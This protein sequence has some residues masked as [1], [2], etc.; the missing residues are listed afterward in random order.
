MSFNGCALTKLKPRYSMVTVIGL[1]QHRY[2][3]SSF[4]IKKVHICY[5]LDL[6]YHFSLSLTKFSMM[7]HLKIFCDVLQ[8]I[9]MSQVLSLSKLN[10]IIQVG[11]YI[12]GFQLTHIYVVLKRVSFL[13]ENEVA[14]GSVFNDLV[15]FP[16]NQKRLCVQ[17]PQMTTLN[18]N[19]LCTLKPLHIHQ[20]F[21]FGKNTVSNERA[22]Y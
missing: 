6:F 5:C 2:S 12:P 8:I 10:R 9:I 15:Y 3:K 14:C 21:F 16:L 17:N 22:A 4:P 20:W 13:V 11:P 1:S 7:N 18:I 19:I